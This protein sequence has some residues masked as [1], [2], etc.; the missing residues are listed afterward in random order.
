MTPRF[1]TAEELAE[2]RRDSVFGRDGCSPATSE[3][4][5]NYIAALEQVAEAARQAR[6]GDCHQEPSCLALNRPQIE[7]CSDCL[8]GAA[9]AAL[10]AGKGEEP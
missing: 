7:M 4:L 6:V 9:L 3:R 1:P 10:D 5:L 8:L 2:I